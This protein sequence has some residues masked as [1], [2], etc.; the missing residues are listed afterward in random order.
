[1]NEHTWL[2]RQEYAFPERYFTSCKVDFRR[3]ERRRQVAMFDEYPG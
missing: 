3:Y 1:M 2:D